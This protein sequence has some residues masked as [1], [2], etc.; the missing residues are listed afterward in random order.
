MGR[1]GQF[2]LDEPADGVDLVL[3]NLCGLAIKYN[4]P[5]GAIRPERVVISAVVV[6][7]HEQ[8][9]FEERFVDDL[10]AIAPAAANLVGWKK[11]FDLLF[12]QLLED[13]LFVTRASINGIPLR[14]LSSIIG[15]LPAPTSN[16]APVQHIRRAADSNGY[17][18]IVPGCGLSNRTCG[19][20][21][22]MASTNRSAC[23]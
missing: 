21:Q 19:S 10:V 4:E 12:S 8:I 13:P 7:V 11:S 23:R 14:H 1:V 18:N 15:D 22:S 16:P 3:G 6:D 17:L 9:V 5:D 20:P 2:T